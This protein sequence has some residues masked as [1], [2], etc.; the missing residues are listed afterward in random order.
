MSQTNGDDIR[1]KMP[2]LSFVTPEEQ[3][4]Q[5]LKLSE[6]IGANRDDP[7]HYTTQILMQSIQLSDLLIELHYHITHGGVLPRQW[8][9]PM[10]RPRWH[11]EPPTDLRK[12]VEEFVEQR[13]REG[14]I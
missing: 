13:N 7:D 11:R 2:G 3:L 8:S 5:M 1:V 6:S 12:R 14:K 9:S 10:Q 4:L